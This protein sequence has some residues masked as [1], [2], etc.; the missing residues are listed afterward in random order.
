MDGPVVVG[1]DWSAHSNYAVRL[2]AAQ[3]RRRRR[4]LRIVHAAGADGDL[5][6]RAEDLRLE[7]A[8]RLAGETAPGIDV[9]TATVA[10]EPAAVLIQEGRDAELVVVGDRGLGG[11]TGLLMGSVAL[12]VATRC[13]QPVLV[14]RGEEHPRGQVVLGVDGSPGSARAVEAAFTEAAL[15]SSDLYAAHAWTGPPP[16]GPG[17]LLPLAYEDD[18]IED[19]ER[20][21]L[22]EALSGMRERFPDVTVREVVVRGRTARSLVHLSETALLMVVGRRGRGGLTGL[23]LGSV[24]QQLLHH[25]ACPVLIVPTDVDQDEAIAPPPG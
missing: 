1:V 9:S 23:L 8:A 5:A 12:H 7:D 10:A 18:E 24:S 21:L 16:A 3:A 25:S 4:P 19:Q 20:R 13:P 22:A 14:A 2:A 15:R 17:D 11:F 6:L